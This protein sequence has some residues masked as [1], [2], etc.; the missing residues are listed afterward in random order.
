[1]STLPAAPREGPLLPNEPRI[2]DPAREAALT[3]THLLPALDE[4]DAFFRALRAGLDDALRRRLPMKD[5][6]PYPKGQCLEISQAAQRALGRLQPQDVGGT[7]ARG[8]AALMAFARAGGTVRQVWGALRETYFQN[9][10]L[11]GTLYVDVANDTVDPAKPP[12]EILPI[13][14]AN[15]APITDYA[16]FARIAHSYWDVVTTP[17]HV[18]PALAPYFPLLAFYPDGSVQLQAPSDYMLALTLTQG[19]APSAQALEAPAMPAE[20]F[21]E[22]TARL[23]GKVKPL[24]PDAEAGRA[25]ALQACARHAA[26]GWHAEPERRTQAV[27]SLLALGPR[28]RGASEG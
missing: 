6:K 23:A 21:A 15:L 18:F 19:F 8:F 1:M 11:V 28:L 5:G 3:A 9:A 17:N 27:Q 4:L 7:P 13:A 16:H 26:N 25:A 20:R 12:V 2:A 22:V 10:F 14:E 24:P